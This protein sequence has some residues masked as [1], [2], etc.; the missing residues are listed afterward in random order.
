MNGETT[1]QRTFQLMAEALEYPQ[2]G[3]ADAVRECTALLAAVNPAAAACLREF[4]TFVEETPPG[5]LEELYTG[6][7]DLNAAWYPY[8][9]YHLFGESYKRSVFMLE[10]NDR[11]RAHGFPEEGLAGEL[12]DHLAV[13]LRFLAACDDD[14]L[15]EEIVQEALL[16]ALDHMDHAMA[17]EPQDHAGQRDY[18][19]VLQALRLVLCQLPADNLPREATPMKETLLF[20]AQNEG[21]AKKASSKAQCCQ[22][23]RRRLKAILKSVVRR[24]ASARQGK[25][26]WLAGCIR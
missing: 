18:G 10:L 11:Y 9:G 23:S 1:R 12:P 21:S 4:C 17:N 26:L 14:A 20:T 3:L 13:L 24:K 22:Y 6:A 15:S 25:E 5:R 8:V 7:F 19:L 16:P 2:P